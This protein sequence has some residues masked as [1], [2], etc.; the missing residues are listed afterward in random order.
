MWTR[1][2]FLIVVLI[3]FL[4][5]P[6]TTS[7]QG[8]VDA[9]FHV[10]APDKKP[11]GKF[12]D[13][14]TGGI[15]VGRVRG[16]LPDIAVCARL[17]GSRPVCAPI[18]HDSQECRG[19]LRAPAGRSLTVE[20]TDM[21]VKQHDPMYRLTVANP[22]SC[23]PCRFKNT[24][25]G[26]TMVLSVEG[27]LQKHT[28][29][30]CPNPAARSTIESMIKQSWWDNTD[31]PRHPPSIG[32]FRPTVAQLNRYTRKLETEFRK[33]ADKAETSRDVVRIYSA[34]RWF[35]QHSDP[36]TFTVRRTSYKGQECDIIRNRIVVMLGGKAWGKVKKYLWKY[37]PT[38]RRNV[39]KLLEEGLKGAIE[40]VP[41]YKNNLSGLRK[42]YKA[43]NDL[44]DDLTRPPPY[45]DERTRIL[46]SVAERTAQA[47]TRTGNGSC[48]YY[49]NVVMAWDYLS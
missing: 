45:S 22:A 46:K 42:D 15:L 44:I 47:M 8:M 21:D 38:N 19:T 30:T 17:A 43:A 34:A 23:K 18:C 31:Y 33:I 28:T 5:A 37:L 6:S 48:L 11:N 14:A 12:W 24:A 13:S 32:S 7:A 10:I 40:S 2:I 36:S 26:I 35:I 27:D 3:F 1:L 29:A 39:K 20:V 9:Q 41:E 49:G 4:T 25:G 16:I